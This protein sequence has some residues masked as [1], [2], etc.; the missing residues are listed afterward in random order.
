MFRHWKE[1]NVD[2]ESSIDIWNQVCVL[3]SKRTSVVTCTIM[4]HR[5]G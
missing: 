2:A 4:I 3:T 5:H 1:V